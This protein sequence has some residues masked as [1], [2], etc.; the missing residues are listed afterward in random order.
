MFAELQWRH[1]IESQIVFSYQS[2]GDTVEV[3]LTTTFRSLALSVITFHIA[4]EGSIL[5]SIRTVGY[6]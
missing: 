5:A 1:Q 6:T 3:S 2:P 4:T